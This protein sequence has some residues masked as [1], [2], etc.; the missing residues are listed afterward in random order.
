MYCRCEFHFRL[1]NTIK[2]H[3]FGSLFQ[4]ESVTHIDLS[5]ELNPFHQNNR[6][7]LF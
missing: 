2:G 7:L 4:T 6:W 1:D 5:Y 3:N